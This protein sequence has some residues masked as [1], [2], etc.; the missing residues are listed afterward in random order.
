MI[1]DSHVHFCGNGDPYDPDAGVKLVRNAMR[2]GIGACVASHVIT[3][4]PDGGAFPSSAKLRAANDFAAVQARKNPG[5]LCFF[6]YLNPQNPDWESELRRGIQ[7]GAVGIKLWIALKN[8]SGGLEETAAVLRA[9]AAARLPVLLHVFNRTGGNLPGEIDM[10]EFAYLS[11]AVPDCVMIAGHTGGNWRESS[12]MLKY[13]SPNTFW[14]LGGSN[15]DRG[16][17]DGILKFC[18]PERLLYGSDA[19]GRAFFPQ[20]WKI[21]ES[22][23]SDAERELVFC[24]NAQRIFRIP[25]PA[26][27]GEIEPF[28]GIPLPPGMEEDHFCFCGKYPFDRRPAVT[29]SDFDRLLASSGFTCAYPAAFECIFHIDLLESNQEF[30]SQCAGLHRLRPLAVV[31]PDAHN[32]EAVLDHALSSG[33]FAGIWVSPAFHCWKLPDRRFYGFFRRCK[34]AELPVWINCGFAEPRF[35]HSSLRIRPVEDAEILDFLKEAPEIACVFQGRIPPGVLPRRKKCRWV[36]SSL[37]DY[38]GKLES[39][40]RMENAP[41]LVWGSEF[42]FRDLRE[43]RASVSAQNR[44]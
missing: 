20:I 17:V 26:S 11:R 12:G 14:E 19:P 16:M 37:S 8:P 35:F 10:A 36:L 43:V 15:P 39:F 2:A 9:A 6:V 38:G 27:C 7:N 13:C 29:P 44:S 30:Q 24:R 5:R 25:D 41:E 28:A 32:W 1:I 22:R 23:L 34:E 40:L 21:L 42:P 18:P 3:T 33:A 4:G 31:N